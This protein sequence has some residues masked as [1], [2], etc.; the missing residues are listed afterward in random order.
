MPVSQAAAQQ[1]VR[2]L[3]GQGCRNSEVGVDTKQHAWQEMI[4][5]GQSDC[6]VHH[7]QACL[8][9]TVLIAPSALPTCDGMRPARPLHVC[10][11][12]VAADTPHRLRPTSSGQQLIIIAGGKQHLVVLHALRA[13]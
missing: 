8:G 5:E 3:Q 4:S 9:I 7:A 2:V 13:A 6:R 10:A 11:G 12:P 1:V